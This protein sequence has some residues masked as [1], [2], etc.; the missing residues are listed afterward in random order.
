ME[1]SR[2]YVGLKKNISLELQLLVAT[3]TDRLTPGKVQ[4]SVL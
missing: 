1:K 2:V 4:L 3:N